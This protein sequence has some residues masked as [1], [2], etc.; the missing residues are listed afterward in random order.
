MNRSIKRS[1]ARAYARE[2]G[3]QHQNKRRV[4]QKTANLH[5]IMRT[6]TIRDKSRFGDF[7]ARLIGGNL[8]GGVEKVIRRIEAR[9]DKAQAAAHKIAVERRGE[10][11]M[12][13]NLKA[14]RFPAACG[15]AQ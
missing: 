9:R 13:M 8:P 6:F 5:G 15:G 10:R 2:L 7:Y 3:I 14:E 12:R 4:A 11:N 1:I